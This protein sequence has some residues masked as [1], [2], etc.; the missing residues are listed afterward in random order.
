M[1][2]WRWACLYK[3]SSTQ[4]PLV[5]LPSRHSTISELTLIECIYVIKYPERDRQ[6]DGCWFIRGTAVYH[7]VR[8][9]DRRCTM[10]IFTTSPTNRATRY[11]RDWTK[12]RQIHATNTD[13][14]LDFSSVL[15][16]RCLA[17]WRWYVRFYDSKIEE[18]YDKGTLR[19]GS[20]SEIFQITR[21]RFPDWAA[22]DRASPLTLRTS[23]RPPT[24]WHKLPP[25]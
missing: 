19:S 8:L 12:R 20:V 7:Q 3:H 22:P 10:I 18:V 25:S 2:R 1:S 16:G 13:A 23:A 15:L 24:L 4:T 21:R 11:I 5:V 17:K 6:D 9:R 14:L